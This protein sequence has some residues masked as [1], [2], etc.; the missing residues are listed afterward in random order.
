MAG[1]KEK[2]SKV[3]QGPYNSVHKAELYAIL[4]VLLGFPE[5]LNI[6]ADSQYIERVVLHIETTEFI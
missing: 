2:V 1:Y 6:V 5:S 3:V 4:M